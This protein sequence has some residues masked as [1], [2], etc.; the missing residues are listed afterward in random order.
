M[1]LTLLLV[2]SLGSQIADAEQVQVLHSEGLTHGFLALRTLDG[3]RSRMA[4][5]RN[6]P[7]AL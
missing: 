6:S 2:I 5:S 3:K 7:K 4:R 1:M